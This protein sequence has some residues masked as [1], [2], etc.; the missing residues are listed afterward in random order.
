M[1]S[2]PVDET[3]EETQ[4]H[5]CPPLFEDYSI[6]E[7]TIADFPVEVEVAPTYEI[8][9]ES[10]IFR[11][12]KLIDNLGYT[13]NVK[14]RRTNAVDWQ[15]TSRGPPHRCPATVIQRPDEIFV[16]GK[17]NHTHCPNAGNYY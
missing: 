16:E 8:V 17:R 2:T 13:Y 5:P 10:T 7:E 14:R 6:V 11:K 15:C 1:S 12:E 3:I 4:P 9:Q